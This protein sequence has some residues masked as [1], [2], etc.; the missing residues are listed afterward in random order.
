[1]LPSPCIVLASESS[2][3][4]GQSNRSSEGYIFRRLV[5][6]VMLGPCPTTNTGRKAR[7]R[8]KRPHFNEFPQ[9][10][11]SARRLTLTYMARLPV[12]G[13]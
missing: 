5:F 9:H 3:L 7:S 4:L 10:L 13:T 8:A 6:Y 12:S 11:V 1:M 2:K